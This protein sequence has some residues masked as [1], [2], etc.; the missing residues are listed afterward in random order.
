MDATIAAVAAAEGVIVQYKT[1]LVTTAL[2]ITSNGSV[3]IPAK[4]GRCAIK[5]GRVL[6]ATFSV[7]A[8]TDPGIGHGLRVPT[9]IGVIEFTR[10]VYGDGI[11]GLFTVYDEGATADSVIVIE[12]FYAP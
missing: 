5:I 6:E 3:Q 11:D 12:S 9:A 2:P 7:T 1:S 10:E 4:R 8:G